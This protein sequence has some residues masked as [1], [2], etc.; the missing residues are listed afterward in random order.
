[1]LGGAAKCYRFGS[2]TLD[3]RRGRLE[4][5]RGIIELRPKSFEV[6]R[7]LVE[8]P[9]RL[10]S[11][12]E[13]LDAVWPDVHVTE[14]SL[15]RCIS[16][17][18]AALGDAGQTMIKN[19]PRRGYILA[20][21]VS[22]T[23]RTAGVQ[24]T[25]VTDVAGHASRGDRREASLPRLSR[26]KTVALV[27][28][29]V[30]LIGAAIWFAFPRQRATTT[31]RASIAVLPFTNLAGDP[32]QD[33]LGEGISAEITASLSKFAQLLVVAEGSSSRYTSGTTDSGRIG[34]EIGVRYLV[35]GSVQRDG[36]RLRIIAQLQEAATGAQ[37]WAQQYD[38]ELAGV[39]TVQDDVTQNIVGTLVAHVSRTELD[40]VMRKPAGSFAA[41]DYYLQGRSLLN[42]IYTADRGLTLARAR[43]LFGKSL[44][45][46]PSYAPA[47]QGMAAADILIWLEPTNHPETSPEYNKKEI[48]ERALDRAQRAVELDRTLSEAYATLA[49]VLHWHYRRDESLAAFER[50]Y[51][52]NPSLADCRYSLILTHRGKPDEG[53]AVMKRTMRLD[54]FHAPVC[55]TWLGNAYY[56][57]GRY[58]EAFQNLSTAANRMPV[59]RPTRVW[60]AAA[61]AQSGQQE[62]AK[63]AVAAVLKQQPELTIAKWLQLLRLPRPED[64]NR[65]ADGMRK[66]GFPD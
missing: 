37:I 49:W 26:T 42:R 54:P 63:T 7:F 13:L 10:I 50:A 18:R 46:D 8:H 27:I 57:S 66:A 22:E 12:E 55:F 32:N 35:R 30:V 17:V 34:R 19:L 44:E 21:P 59:H 28:L 40:R 53:I 56:L 48:L 29:S 64:A 31:E 2:F 41:Y 23:E 25:P 4:G 9:E 3:L 36:G 6:L 20:T 14:D 65:L 33:Y 45:L 52:L 62:I 39:F 38:R 43:G 51:E 5:E 16:E 60:L 24:P 58:D 15:T 61:A 11:K 1:M 47:L